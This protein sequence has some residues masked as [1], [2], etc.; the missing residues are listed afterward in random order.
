MIERTITER[1]KLDYSDRKIVILFGPRQVGKTTLLKS[2]FTSKD[3]L[4][5]NGDDYDIR[6]QLAKPNAT[7]L[8]QL[9]A[10]NKTLII[11]EAQRIENIGLCLKIIHD[12]LPEIKVLATGSSSFDLANKINEPLTGRKWEYKLWP[13]SVNEMINHHTWLE[14]NRL[15]QQRLIYGWYPEVI[16][17]PGKEKDLLHQLSDSYLYKDLLT[18]QDIKKPQKLEALV[19]ALALQIGSQVSYHEIGQIIGLNNETVE[20]YI[21]LLEKAFIVFRLSSFSRNLR[22]ELKKSKK[23]Y[24]YDVGIRNAVIQNWKPVGLR[25]DIGALWENFL[26]VERLKYKANTRLQSNDYFWR[27]HAQ[28]EIDFI[29]EYNDTIFAYEFKWNPKRNAKFSKS[30]T[31][32]YPNH[33]LMVVT[34]NNYL[35]FITNPL[36]ANA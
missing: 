35:E 5:L 15:L 13:I 31:N 12:Q 2:Y 23:I 6:Q 30:F 14:E 11:D 1:I 20:R 18:W 27:T 29:E 9:I 26:I 17:N 34:P 19:Q 32:A 33:K 7:F 3:T 16:N 25:Q 24:F 10:N 8:K 22:N 4:W 36:Q 21:Q 28:A